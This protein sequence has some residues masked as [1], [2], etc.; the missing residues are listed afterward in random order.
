MIQRTRAA[1]PPKPGRQNE[2]LHFVTVRPPAVPELSDIA[3][4]SFPICGEIRRGQEPGSAEKDR[5]EIVRLFSQG[6]EGQALG[7][8][9]EGQFV[10]FVTERGSDFLEERGIA[11][12]SF[13]DRLDARGLALKSK[14]R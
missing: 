3:A 4:C 1:E 7:E 13:D 2:T 8:E 5:L 11:S 6:N 10:L 12:V 14:L 9:G